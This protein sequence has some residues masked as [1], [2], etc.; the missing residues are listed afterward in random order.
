MRILA[1]TIMPN[2]W[3]LVLWPEGDDDLS[4]FMHWLTLA[5]TQRWHKA[6]GSVGTG[7]IYQG[8]FKSFPVET[9]DHFW[10]VCRYVERNPLRANLVSLAQNWRWS[11]LW[12]WQNSQCD[13]SVSAWPLPCPERLARARE[14]N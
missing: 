14:R 1:Y 2:H 12:Q 7:P 9:D 10:S 4:N 6:H 8:R 13:V 3:H 11:S 5:H